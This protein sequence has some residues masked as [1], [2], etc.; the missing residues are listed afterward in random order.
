[1]TS[2]LVKIKDDV[3][4]LFFFFLNNGGVQVSLQEDRNDRTSYTREDG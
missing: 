4:D 1:M 3:S 2:A